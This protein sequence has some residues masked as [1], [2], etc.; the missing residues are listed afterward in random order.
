VLVG[1]GDLNV[2]ATIPDNGDIDYRLFGNGFDQSYTTPRLIPG[3]TAGSYNWEALQVQRGPQGTLYGATP[4]SGVVNITRNSVTDLALAYELENVEVQVRYDIPAGVVGPFGR[5]VGN[6]VD[7]TFTEAEGTYGFDPGNYTIEN[8]DV[9]PQGYR[10]APNNRN[11]LLSLSLGVNYLKDYQ[12]TAE[13]GQI[14][15]GTTGAPAGIEDKAT[16]IDPM[17]GTWDIMLPYSGFVAPGD[18]EVENKRAVFEDAD[19]DRVTY[20]SPRISG[21]Q[22]GVTVGQDTEVQYEYDL[23]WIRTDWT[24]SFSIGSDIWNHWDKVNMPSTMTLQL[25]EDQL[26]PGVVKV[27]GEVPFAK[28]IGMIDQNGQVNATGTGDAAGFSNVPF[29]VIGAVDWISDKFNGELQVGQ[30]TPPTGLP[31]GSIRYLFESVRL[32]F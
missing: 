4:S 13:R 16:L 22:L 25:W 31:N 24:A 12:L 11:D 14:I 28:V 18:W 26:N 27:K 7:Y 9:D 23:S 17:G 8:Y 6:G 19:N 21:F 15:I 29:T 1:T 32:R 2:T 20:F 3:L 30:D 5:I 10:F